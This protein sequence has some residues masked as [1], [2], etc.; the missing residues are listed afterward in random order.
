MLILQCCT[1]LMCSAGSPFKVTV[2][3]VSGTSAEISGPGICAQ[4]SQNFTFDSKKTGNIPET[5]TVITP[6]GGSLTSLGIAKNFVLYIYLLLF[7][8]SC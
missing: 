6:Q 2:K 7:S 8:F 3:D 4:S 1:D 5:A